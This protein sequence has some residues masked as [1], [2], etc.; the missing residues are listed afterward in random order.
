MRSKRLLARVAAMERQ[1][2]I[3]DPMLIVV[4]LFRRD[5]PAEP[6]RTLTEAEQ[7]EFAEAKRGGASVF[8]IRRPV[9]YQPQEPPYEPKRFR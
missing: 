6:D 3:A 5:G 8:V 9:L 1:S 2:G 7:V 4:K